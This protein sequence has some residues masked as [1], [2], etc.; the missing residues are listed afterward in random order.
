LS[1]GEFSTPAFIVSGLENPIRMR[2]LSYSL[3]AL[4]T[5]IS[6]PQLV[7]QI[8]VSE[9]IRWV[10]DIERF[11]AADLRHFPVAGSIVFAGS[12][13]IAGWSTLNKDFGYLPVLNR[14][15]GGSTLHDNVQSVD[16]I[17]LPYK[18]PLIVLYSGENDLAEGRTPQQVLQD[19]QTFVSI[20]HAKLP[21]T[22]IVF[23]SIK[24]SIA[25]WSMTDSIRATNRLIQD[26]VG[27]DK[28][29]HYI[30]VFTPMLDASGQVRR[31][32][33]VA[34]GLHMNARGYSIWRRLI[35]PTLR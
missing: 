26:Y 8:A 1:I 10:S 6:A 33:F 15:I 24:P 3:I 21:A 31:E 30:D 23:V 25:R 34:D 27:T 32:L 9:P 22:R 11:E 28:K 5:L 29:L 18:P 20:V 19:F 2:R 14:G 35:Q 16:R 12:S 4:V 7:C 17:I 13:S